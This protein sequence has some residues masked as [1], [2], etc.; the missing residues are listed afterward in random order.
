MTSV[1]DL[2]DSIQTVSAHGAPPRATAS[3]AK[4]VRREVE[5]S[6]SPILWPMHFVG[7]AAQERAVSKVSQSEE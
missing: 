3:L 5:G 6:L 1:R 7:M 2:I 4:V